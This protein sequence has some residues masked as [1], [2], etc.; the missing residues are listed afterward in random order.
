MATAVRIEEDP[1]LCTSGHKGGHH[2]IP[3][4]DALAQGLEL[5]REIAGS[6]S[7]PL[8][9]AIG[10]ICARPVASQIDMPPFDNSAMDGY[11]VRL[12]D[13]EDEGPWTLPLA[14][15][16][17]AGDAAGGGYGSGVAVR[18]LTGAPVPHGFDAVVMQEKCELSDGC[19]HL[20]KRPKSGENIRLAGEDVQSGTR[21]VADG[22][23]I[24]PREL[25]VL[26]AAGC[27]KVEV[28]PRLKV[29]FFCTGSELKQPGER[30]GEGQI[31]NSNRFTLLSFLSAPWIETIDMGA[32]EDTPAKLKAAL[33]EAADKADLV[34][35]TGGVSVGDEDH[36]PRL[37]EEAGGAIHAMKVA[38][39]PGKPLVIGK[40][41][42]AVYLGLPGNPVAAFV[43][44]LVIGSAMAEKMAGR[45]AGKVKTCPARLDRELRRAPF[46]TEY[47]PV[48]ITSYDPSGMPVVELLAASF[49][50]RVAMLASAD[51]LVVLPRLADRI[52]P[53]ET[54]QFI[55]L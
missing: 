38:I 25:S 3:V 26:A 22:K 21:I 47:R 14:G 52:A 54:L 37:V 35:T 33:I 31:Y 18:I 8:E 20:A 16:I 17:A 44:W 32:I 30:L 42:K 2:L 15:R 36:M 45:T 29:A 6:V 10:R 55:P 46:R 41:G 50:A 39:K 9:E 1:C 7:L 12:S 34:I 19:I 40:I 4:E 28:K 24:G 5:A 48:R 11:A 13:L 53:S 49:S 23:L 27:P 51:G 43:T